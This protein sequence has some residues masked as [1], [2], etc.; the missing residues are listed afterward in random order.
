MSFV[1]VTLLVLFGAHATAEDRP[2]SRHAVIPT[3]PR[4]VIL[5]QHVKDVL[6]SDWRAHANDP[7]ILERAYCV[8][9][10]KDVW[11]IPE[12]VWR[13]ISIR[14]ADH[15]MGQTPTSILALSCNPG[16]A[17]LHVHPPQSCISDTECVPGGS[18]ADQCFPSLTDRQSL[19]RS[20]E[21]WAAVQCDEHAVVFW[22]RESP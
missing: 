15:V 2:V 18:L 4:Y 11:V 10:R 6:A 12:F 5:D 20:T 19:N 14:P 3:G 17:V 1:L 13:G 9:Y 8:E 21:A 7:A 22:L 16:E